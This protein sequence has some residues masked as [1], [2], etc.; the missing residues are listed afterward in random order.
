MAIPSR[1]VKIWASCTLRLRRSSSPATA[2]TTVGFVGSTGSGKTTLID[3][4]LGLLAPQQGR[5]K[6]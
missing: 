3:L 6:V 2:A 5:L 1:L 4:L